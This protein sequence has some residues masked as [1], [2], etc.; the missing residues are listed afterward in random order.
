VLEGGVEQLRKEVR[1]NMERELGDNIRARVKQQ[2]MEG[3]LA[4][5]PVE[6][7]GSLVDAQ[8]REMQMEA[9]RRMGARDAAQLPPADPFVE[10]ARRRVALGLLIG[11]LIRTRGVKLDR[12]RVDARLAELASGY[13]EPEQ[14]IKAYRQNAEALRQI[15]NIVIEEQVVDLLLEQAKV[16]D[17]PATFKDVMNFGA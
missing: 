4:A 10:G 6:V 3:L 2:L 17:Q 1:D 12:A 5:N 7:P 15:E 9:A 11:E 13:P 16:T 8:V 14:V